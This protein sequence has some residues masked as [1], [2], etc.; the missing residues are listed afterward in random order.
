M[1]QIG[2][3]SF[4]TLGLFNCRDWDD[5]TSLIYSMQVIQDELGLIPL[6]SETIEENGISGRIALG[7]DDILEY[8]RKKYDKSLE[9][10]EKYKREDAPVRQLLFL[11]RLPFIQDTK[12]FVPTNEEVTILMTANKFKDGFNGIG[13][14]VILSRRT[15]PNL[16]L[17]R[18]YG[19]ELIQL[20]VSM[21][22]LLVRSL[23]PDLLRIAEDDEYSE[24]YTKDDIIARRVKIIYWANYFGPGYLDDATLNLFLN[25]PVGNVESYQDGIWYQLHPLFEDVNIE[26]VE[27]IEKEAKLYFKPLNIDQVQWKYYW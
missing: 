1:P 12:E 26:E 10:Y 25:A 22:K 13:F 23:A 16:K 20:Y 8:C 3:G 17:T 7:R 18:K 19:E 2:K 15:E 4:F 11:F 27:S 24:G 5:L 9:I 21:G 6:R 14:S